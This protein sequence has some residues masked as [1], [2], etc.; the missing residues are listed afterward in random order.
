MFTFLKKILFAIHL[1]KLGI[2]FI[3]FF[4]IFFINKKYK[5]DYTYL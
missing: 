3:N 2:K 4:N 5:I 1:N